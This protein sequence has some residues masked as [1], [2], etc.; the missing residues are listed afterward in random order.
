MPYASETNLIERCSETE[1]RLIADR[2]KDGFSDPEVTAAALVD[3][4]NRIN[5]YVGAKYHLPLQSVPSNVVTW[6]VS[7]ARYTLHRNGAPKH[8]KDD[9]EDA[10]AAL[11]DV[12]R[13]LIALPVTEGETAPDSAS[14]TVM[15]SHP[16]TVFTRIKLR[17]WS[18]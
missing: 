13:G 11:K 5:G 16:P 1:L 8:V 2:D 3:A 14:G 6:A 18:R 15:A 12:A 7:I 9:Y 10:I 17:G 4:D